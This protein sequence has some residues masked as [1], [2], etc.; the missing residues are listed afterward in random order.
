MTTVARAR[1]FLDGAVAGRGLADLALTVLLAGVLAIAGCGDNRQPPQQDAAADDAPEPQDARQNDLVADPMACEREYQRCEDAGPGFCLDAGLE[2][3]SVRVDNPASVCLRRCADTAECPFNSYCVPTEVEWGGLK[4]AAHHCFGSV[5]GQAYGNGE[6]FGACS[7]GGDNLVKL[8]AGQQRPGTCIPIDTDAGTGACLESGSEADGGVTSGRDQTCSLDMVRLLC[9]PRA[10]VIACV[11]GTTCIGQLCQEYGNCALLCD[12]RLD[13]EGQCTVGT[14]KPKQYCQD[15][16]LLTLGV[17]GKLHLG[18]V[19]V[20]QANPLC[21]L[22]APRAD[23]GAPAAGCD[24]TDE[25]FPSTMA[26]TNGVCFK[27]GDPVVGAAC[28]Y[29]NDCSAGSIC[30]G[31]DPCGAGTCRALCPLPD[32]GQT[33]GAGLVCAGVA[34]D[35]TQPTV[36]SIPWGVCLEPAAARSAGRPR[37]LVRPMAA[38][39]P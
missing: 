15:V 5:C 39:R 38:R 23:G 29:L 18:Y 24:P 16:S 12:P 13:P 31:G 27:P 34:L 21:R 6:L 8:D 17:S 4:L 2:C 11:T 25:C 14:G 9:P 3:V 37:T 28:A 36:K 19:G 35:S 20:C 26:T 30:V 33:C 32:D 7:V 10:E 1:S 22:F